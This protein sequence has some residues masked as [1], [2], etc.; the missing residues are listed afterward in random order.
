M[1]S[2]LLKIGYIL[3][4]GL[5]ST[6]AVHA[7]EQDGSMKLQG[8]AQIASLESGTQSYCYTQLAS[9]KGKGHHARRSHGKKQYTSA[10]KQ[11]VK[12]IRRARASGH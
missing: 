12:K 1:S 4:I 10:R 3:G 5:L 6:Q 7:F 11:R 8:V 2:Q 9:T